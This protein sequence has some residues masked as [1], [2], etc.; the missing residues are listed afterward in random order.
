VLWIRGSVLFTPGTQIQDKFFPDLGSRIFLTL[1]KTT[2]RL[3]LYFAP[4]SIRSKKKVSLHSTFHVG[5]R[6]KKCLDPDPGSGM[7]KW[8]DPESWMKHPGSAILLQRL[9][10]ICLSYKKLLWFLS[11]NMRYVMKDNNN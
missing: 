7:R 6:L 9:R 10:M 3:R 5:S 11:V 8:S 1:T 2:L 4:E